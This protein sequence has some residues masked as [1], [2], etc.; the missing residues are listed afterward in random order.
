MKQL[1]VCVLEKNEN[2]IKSEKC[3]WMGMYKDDLK[4]TKLDRRFMD[5][6]HQM[7]KEGEVIKK[8]EHR[9]G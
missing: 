5:V 6:R 4:I 7:L 1:T 8:K 9:S 3:R 2:E